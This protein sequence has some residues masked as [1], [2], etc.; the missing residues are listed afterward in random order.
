MC[1]R[2]CVRACVLCVC[3][4]TTHVCVNA[5]LSS[6]ASSLQGHFDNGLQGGV[7]VVGSPDEAC[8]LAKKMLGARLITKQTGDDGRP[9]N[10]V[11][12]P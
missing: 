4:T 6:L 8:E 1:V 3:D 11:G 9:C 2:A 5:D 7:H 12:I 10:K